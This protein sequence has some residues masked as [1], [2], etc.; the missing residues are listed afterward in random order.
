MIPLRDN[1]PNVHFPFAVVAIIAANLVA[2]V[3]EEFQQPQYLYYIFHVYG[4]VPARFAHPDIATM[5]GY[6][7][8]MISLVT[9]MFLHGGW[10]HFIANMWMLWIFGDNVED[11][12]GPPRFVAFYLLCGLC[13][14]GAHMLSDV[15]SALPIVGASGAVAG[16]M[17]AYMVLYP[18]GRVLTLIPLFFVPLF[19]R[20]PSLVFLGLWFLSQILSGVMSFDGAIVQS[21]AWW[22]HIG[23]FMGGVVMIF[24]FR[25]KNRCYYCFNSASRDY[26]RRPQ[27]PGLG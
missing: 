18:H 1:V 27:G 2:F 23:G 17:G 19:F 10:W 15:D 24:L 20:V 25:R 26:D 4:V 7:D 8:S 5:A 22:A 6:P 21:V 12:M 14:V 13:A 16:V 9:Y 3:W 11:V